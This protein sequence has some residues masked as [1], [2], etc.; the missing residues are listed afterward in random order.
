MLDVLRAEGYRPIGVELSFKAAEFCR[1][2]SLTVVAARCPD[3]PFRPGGF[4]LVLAG[5]HWRLCQGLFRLLDR[6]A[7]GGELI[8]AAGRVRTH[9]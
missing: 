5:L 9:A 7:G 1:T 2:K 6:L 4:D 8:V 3:L